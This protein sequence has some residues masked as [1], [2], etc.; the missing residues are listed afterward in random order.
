MTCMEVYDVFKHFL[1]GGQLLHFYF[2]NPNYIDEHHFTYFFSKL[3]NYAFI[4]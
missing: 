3:S 2:L 4:M 1:F